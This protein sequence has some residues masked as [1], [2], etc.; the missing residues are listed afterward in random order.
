M[1]NKSSSSAADSGDSNGCTSTIA[2]ETSTGWH[3]LNVKGYTQSRGILGPGNCID[4]ES[5]TVGGHSWCIKYYPDGIDNRSDHWISVYLA[6]RR[7][8]VARDDAVK[9]RVKFVLLDHDGKPVPAHM[10]QTREAHTFSVSGG[11]PLAGFRCF[12]KRYGILEESN[13]LKDDCLSIGCEVTVIKG[14]GTVASSTKE[15]V[16]VPPPDLNKELAKLL[17]DGHGADVKFEVG[18]ELF[19]AHRSILAAR[20]SVFKAELFGPM[21]EMTAARVRVHDMEPNVFRAMLH[22]IYT[23][24]LP[25]IGAGEKMAMAQH[26]LVAADRYDLKRL[27]L[28]SEDTLCGHI[29]RRTAVSMLVL[30]DLH[31]CIGLKEACFVFLASRDNLKAAMTTKDYDQLRSS[32]PS[33]LDELVASLAHPDVFKGNKVKR[34]TTLCFSS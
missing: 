15:F 6:L 28:I 32:C 8:A 22:F 12:I 30:A 13:Y 14:I 9:A 2:A 1:G 23:D 25:A 26:L 33:L 29:D 17:L 31:G 16:K 19:S 3:I 18:S 4:S 20:S 34:P 27:K 24:S 11:T 7:P 21:E 10:L 5:F